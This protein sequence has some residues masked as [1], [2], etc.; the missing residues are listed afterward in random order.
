[1]KAVMLDFDGVVVRSMEDH[2]EGW[3]RALAEYGIEM[4]PEELFV[5]EGTGAEE[6]ASQ[7]TRKFNLPFEEAG[8]IIRKKIAYYDELKNIELYPDLL[9]LLDWAGDRGLL[10]ALVTNS[11]PDWV[12]RTLEEFGLTDRF[13][14]IITAEDFRFA[15]PAPEPFL[16]AAQQLSVDPEET[17]VLENAPLGIRAA[18]AAGMRCIALATTL[19]P[20][21]LKEADVVA[22]NL[23]EALDALKRMY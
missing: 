22:D 2:Y 14:A 20:K 18:R 5:I 17:V 3:R 13:E 9:E 10:T 12:Y 4:L 7:F 23:S 11:E 6:I 15:K 16:R 19:S 1:M 21:Y 8:N